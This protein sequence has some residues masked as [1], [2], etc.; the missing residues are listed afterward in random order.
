MSISKK[1]PKKHSIYIAYIKPTYFLLILTIKISKIYVRYVRY[2]Y[3]KYQT[4][5][6]HLVGSFQQCSM[7]CHNLGLHCKTSRGHSIVQELNP[8]KWDPQMN[9]SK[10]HQNT[11]THE[12]L[13]VGSLVLKGLV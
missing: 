13:F 6:K 10:I 9:I 7:F 4:E 12:V 5:A 8:A 11:K 1:S 2:M 3:D